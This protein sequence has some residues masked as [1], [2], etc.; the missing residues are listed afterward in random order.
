MIEL[1]TETLAALAIIIF[2]AGGVTSFLIDR[3]LNGERCGDLK[4][5]DGHPVDLDTLA[6]IGVED[7][8]SS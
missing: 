3:R 1:R 2:M 5:D 6:T 7:D 4:T 8:T